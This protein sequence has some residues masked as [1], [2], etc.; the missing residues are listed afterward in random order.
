MDLLLNIVV[1]IF[2]AFVVAYYLNKCCKRKM[3]YDKFLS[4]SV[5]IGILF[6][7]LEMQRLFTPYEGT[8]GLMFLGAVIFV[9]SAILFEGKPT[10][11]IFMSVL[12]LVL[13]TFAA[14]STGVLMSIIVGTDYI[15]LVSN[16]SLEKNISMLI[17]QVLLWFM[18]SMAIKIIN[19]EKI[20]GIKDTLY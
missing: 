3:K 15:A 4:Y 14:L 11:K 16:V 9:L 6:V 17:N 7:Y 20:G 5:I 8:L 12:I 10:K 19:K 18:I 2:Q 1:N 13:A